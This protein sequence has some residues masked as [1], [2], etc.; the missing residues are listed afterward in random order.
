MNSDTVAISRSTNLTTP[1]LDPSSYP[2]QEE[3][4]FDPA[5]GASAVS[6]A[7]DGQSEVPVAEASTSSTSLSDRSLP[8]YNDAFPALPASDFTPSLGQGSQ[9][10]NSSTSAAAAAAAAMNNKMK[11]KSTTITSSYRLEPDNVRVNQ[12]DSS[13]SRSDTDWSRIKDIM[14][15]TGTVIE[16]CSSKDGSLTFLIKGKQD[17]VRA[18]RL[19]LGAEM[20][21]QIEHRVHIPK[22]HHKV[23]LGKNG[24][25]LK[26]LQNNTG[27]KVIVPDK[28]DP[29]DAIKI[30]GTKAAIEKATHEIQVISSELASKST[31]KLI[32]SKEYH[33]F[34]N[35]PLGETVKKIM[36]DTG[37]KV[38][39]PPPSVSSNEITI[40]GETNAV[41]RA[42]DIISQIVKEKQRKCTVVHVEVKKQQHRYVIGP[43]GQVLQEILRQTG[44]SIEV[45]PT[46]NPSETITLRGEQEKLGP[47]LTLLYE[48]AHSEIDEEIDAPS[49]LQKYIIGPKG[50]HFQEISQE[51]HSTVNVSFSAAENKISIRGPSKDVEKARQVLENEIRRISRDVLVR[52]MKVDAKYHKFLIGKSGQTI[53]QIREKTG[54]QITI[55]TESEGLSNTNVIR[56][57]GNASAVESAKIELE[58]IIKKRMET[59]SLVTQELNIEQRFHKLI[60]GVKGENIKEIRER[61][62]QVSHLIHLFN[63]QSIVTNNLL[64]SSSFLFFLSF[65]SGCDNFSSF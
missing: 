34:I 57:E 1:I 50:S 18:A 9:V 53:N 15:R 36:N 48:K 5:V 2:D 10:V 8:F 23:V 59:D 31:E 41:T 13:K 42:K 49:W 47:A 65:S 46:D 33:P 54:A 12:S 16:K 20:E 26:D 21:T 4:N 64:T 25:K 22:A 45:P 44:V 38:N 30:I 19:L 52:E 6:I 11:V 32:V 27:A 14:S 28:S 61:F 56:I 62:N 37:A 24:Q 35:G 40:N 29:S 51:F 63:C 60:I 17:N 43:K 55:P 58:A 7:Q 3:V 39:I